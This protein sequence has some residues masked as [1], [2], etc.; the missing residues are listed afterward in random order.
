MER[1]WAASGWLE[2]QGNQSGCY[3]NRCEKIVERV[4][5][6]GEVTAASGVLPLSPPTWR[7]EIVSK[8]TTLTFPEPGRCV[9]FGID[10]HYLNFSDD[11][12]IGIYGAGVSL[13]FNTEVQQTAAHVAHR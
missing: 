3:K 1:V 7:A 10:R 4:A 2:A 9:Q 6:A 8:V 5:S 13:C 12:P 11:I